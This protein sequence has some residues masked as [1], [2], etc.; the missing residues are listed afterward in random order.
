VHWQFPEVVSHF[1]RSP[2]P[3]SAFLY[4]QTGHFKYPLGAGAAAGFGPYP[5]TPV[6]LLA[7]QEEPDHPFLQTQAPFCLLQSPR[8]G[9][10]HSAFLYGQIGH[11]EFPPVPYVC[12][13]CLEHAPPFHWFLQTHSPVVLS[14]S[15]RFGPP[16]STLV[17]GQIGHF[18]L[19][20]GNPPVVVCGGGFRP[21]VVVRSVP[22]EVAPPV[23]RVV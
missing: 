21:P 12:V 8:V 16:H 18:R 9:P 4:G 14:Q 22:V 6:A 15:P 1:P 11:L 3:H 23:P 7:E 19:G 10:P 20:R 13:G 2:P 5:E 17:T